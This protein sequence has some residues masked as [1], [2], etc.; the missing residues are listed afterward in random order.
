VTRAPIVAALLAL[1]PAAG[2]GADAAPTSAPDVP[3]DQDLP[4]LPEE[5][6]VVGT[7]SPRRAG[8]LPT[9]V[10]VVP[11][12]DVARGPSPTVDGALRQVPSFATFRRSTS[13]AADPSSQG[14]NLRG[15]A[16]SAVA[17]T[18]LLDD[19]VPVNDAFGGWIAWR[20]IPRLGLE[21]IEVAPGGASALYGSFALGGVVALVPRPVTGMAFEAESF[22]GSFGTY[23][24]A[25]R[26]AHVVGRLSGAIE[27]EHLRTRGYEVVAPGASGPVDGE[28][29]ARHTTAS[30]RLALEPRAGL[31][32]T[33][34]GAFFDEDQ[35][36][37][38]R[39]TRAGLRSWTGRAGLERQGRLARTQLLLYGGTRTFAQ[40]R[41]RVSADRT[42]EAL[43]AAQRVPSTDIGG[44]VLAALEPLR[45]HGL[46]GGADLRRVS[47]ESDEAL[48][49]AAVTPASAVA[50][51]A[52]GTQW[53]GGLFVQD[54]WMPRASFELA[55]ALRAD[56][57]RA[58]DGRSA[59]RLTDGTTIEETFPARSA[60][61]L[62]PRLAARWTPATPL[63]L[64][65]SAYRAFRAPTLNELYRP[66]QVGTV[67][68]APNPTLRAEVVTGAEVGPDIALPGGV[69]LRATAFWNDLEDP[70][71]TVTLDA[72]LDDGATRRR[73]NLGHAEI[74][75]VESEAAWRPL[76]G[77]LWSV[78]WT[79]AEARV[80][81]APAR[82]DLVGKLLPHDPVHRVTGKVVF[83]RPGVAAA[84]A[85]VRWL[86][87]AWEDDLNTLPLPP[88]ALF[89]AAVSRPFG[90]EVELFAAVENLLDRRVLVGRAGV[91]TVGA[92]RLVRVGVRL[93][94]A[95]A[96]RP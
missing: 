83:E 32:L 57:W 77:V 17:R 12:E 7:R 22:G 28:A 74:R 37:G 78:A 91:D 16:P 69:R 81:S 13:L 56:V 8:S 73:E 58:E 11:G 71:A 31:R 75:G 42:A 39:H 90:R 27:A 47:G 48:F 33:A 26:T 59:R 45:H 89:D 44:S 62:S 51:I 50:R 63:T 15:I 82:P 79:V 80:T 46:S 93:R 14:L 2:L 84:T 66:F 61:V 68:T 67:L 1:V 35:E 3:A 4:A 94:S 88:F 72:P 60:T 95:G 86:S 18:L 34:G 64:R 65:A 5:V 6:V 29:G 92:P 43:A 19:G 96:A 38:T 70:I 54:A 53:T 23:G 30:L 24:L 20:S 10:F 40:E 36:G 85:E 21:R 25:G 41:A 55:G 9:T 52:S 76:R 49:P 87:R